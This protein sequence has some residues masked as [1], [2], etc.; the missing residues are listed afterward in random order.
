MS[1]ELPQS[2]IPLKNDRNR[3]LTLLTAIGEGLCVLDETGALEFMNPVAE[4]LLGYAEA[5]LAGRNLLTLIEL[6]TQREEAISLEEML[7]QGQRLYREDKKFKRKDGSAFPVAYTLSPVFEG[8][9]FISAVLLF[10]D[11]SQSK[12][13]EEQLSILTAAIE[14]SPNAVLIADI[15]G[16]IVYVN[17]KFTELTGYAAE[18]VIGKNPRILKSGRTG[19]ERY[20]RL[21]DAILSGGEWRGE[22]QDRK[23]NGELYWALESISPIRNPQGEITHFL[24]IQKDITEQK[25]AQ[26]ALK[27]SEERFRQVAEMTGEWIWEQDPEGH[28]IYSSSAVKDILGYE[29]EE[30][31][32]KHYLELFTPEEQALW[33]AEAEASGDIDGMQ[34]RFFRITNHYYHKKDGHEVYTEST[35]K[36]IFDAQGTLIKWRGVD[37]DITRR[38]CYEDALRL[39]DRAIEAA[40]VGI[41]IVDA[42][43]KGNPN[44]YVNE[45]LCR[46]TGYSREEL[47]GKNL[48]I[49]QGPD[50]EPAAVQKIR[51]ALEEESHCEVILKNYKKDGTPFWNELL[52]SPVRDEKGNLTHYIGIQTDV[53]ERR[54]AEEERHELEIAKHIQQSLLPKRPLRINGIHVAGYCLPAT[55]VGGDYFDYFYTPQDTVDAVIADVSG[56]SVGAALVMAEA[57]S[58]LLAETRKAPETA[59]NSAQS[60][61]EVLYILNEA[62]YEDLDRAEQFITLF[63]AKYHPSTGRLD[64]ANAG[65]NYPLLVRGGECACIKLD[66]D[67]LILGV[68]PHVVFEEKTLS[69]HRG[70]TLLLYTDGIVEAQDR[71]GTFFGLSRLCDLFIQQSRHAPQV[72]ID[73]IIKELEIFCQSDT[74]EDDVSLVV[75][76]IT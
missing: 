29:P 4:Q 53:T 19:Q 20:Q 69:L 2:L 58:A 13:K 52:I 33:K 60:A 15:N 75:M 1:K 22:I 42:R 40:S 25:Q 74:F 27:E 39:R 9:V 67:G 59:E 62:L 16:D 32:G 34:K 50:T 36:P 11:I 41:S 17:P 51:K 73:N 70:D 76:K 28:Y 54:R 64:Y 10:R 68:M 6:P 8:K 48:S 65:H 56:H 7:G 61:A 24:A 14:Q 71:H 45:A 3:L 21:W 12:K 38:K 30:I 31:I 5:E 55:H 72:I 63:Y 49:L 35:G 18:E 37:H 43:Q 57:R 47:I 26:E 23:K 44:I 46:L 66:A